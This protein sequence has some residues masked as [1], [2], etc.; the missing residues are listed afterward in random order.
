M[1]IY[2]KNNGVRREYERG[3][4]LTEVFQSLDLDFQGKPVCA[5]V[6]NKIE[7]LKY[8]VY[9]SKQVEFLTIDSEPGRKVYMRSMTFVLYKAVEELYPKAQLTVVA[10]ASHGYF[11]KLKIENDNGEI[12]PVT[13]EISQRLKHRMSDII[14]EQHHFHRIEAPTEDVARLFRERHLESKAKLIEGTRMIYSYYYLLDK[15]IDYYY[16]PLVP[17]TDFLDDFDLVKYYDGLLL[18]IP[19]HG[20]FPEIVKQE[21]ML[22]AFDESHKL[23]EKGNVT[24]IGELND[25]TRKGLSGYAIMVAEAL[26]EKK[27]SKIAEQIAERPSVKVVLVAGPSSSGKTTFSKRLCVQLMACGRLPRLISLDDYFVDRE[28]TP[29]DE[30]GDFDYESIYALNLDKFQDDLTRLLAGEEVELPVYNFVEGRSEMSGK[31]LR[32]DDDTVLVMEGIHGLNPLMSERVPEECKFRIYVSA[33]TSIKLD[34]HNYIPPSDNRLIRRIVRDNKYRG[35]SAIDTIARWPSVRRGE[36]RWIFPFQENA[37]VMFNSALIYELAVL[38]DHALPLLE[39]VGEN[40]PEHT[41]ADALSKFLRYIEPISDKDL[42]PT[43]LLREFL[44]GSSFK[45]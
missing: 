40:R 22:R 4:M 19:N 28:K 31:K 3:I 7:G 42:P 41:L 26:Q 39:S 14:S 33:L 45:Y 23:L 24:T 13:L 5:L 44:G 27:I 43:S 29:I 17:S 18:R 37:D 15:T 2:C 25:L 10:P 30:N 1:E 6:N 35:A 38:R 34:S 8:R 32:L 36:E 21:K 12:V 20:K 16:G 9:N 11:F